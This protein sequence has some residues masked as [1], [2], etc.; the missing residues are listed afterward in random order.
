MRILPIDKARICPVAHGILMRLCDL[1]FLICLR[2]NMLIRVPVFGWQAFSMPA[3]FRQI[4]QNAL[5]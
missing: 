4:A 1:G 5:I 3:G 2:V